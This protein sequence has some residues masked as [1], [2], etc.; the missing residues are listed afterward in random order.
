MSNFILVHGSWHGAWC[1]HKIV[2]RLRALGHSVEAIDIPGHGR[3]WTNPAEITLET[4]SEC[5]AKA[6][7]RAP[8]PVVVVAHSR[9]GIPTSHA[10]EQRHEQISHLVY[11]AAYLLA[12]GET[13]LDHVPHD[14][15]SLVLP[16]LYFDPDGHW[17]MLKA[18]AFEPALYAD[19][20]PEDIA[21][22]HLLLTPEPAAPSRT[23]I[24]INEECYGTIPRTYIELLEDRAVS[25]I[26]Q[27]RMHSARPATPRTSPSPTSSWRTSTRS[28]RA[29]KASSPP[30]ASGNASRSRADPREDGRLASRQMT[31]SAEGF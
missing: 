2:P 22:G 12:D 3:D 26:L 29:P 6:I 19:C 13:V 25:P 11:L 24:R 14:T 8:G 30:P 9:G 18:E 15:D 10:A 23:P 28:Q 21:L 20:S 27:K 1:W 31:H 7:D 5:I 4:Y 17:D 16:N